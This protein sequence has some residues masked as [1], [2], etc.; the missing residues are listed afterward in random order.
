LFFDE[1]PRYV[2]LRHETPPQSARPL[3][4]DL[5]LE[6]GSTLRTWAL[7]REP[8][9]GEAVPAEALPD[10]RLDYLNYE[11]P[12]SN[13]R[14]F[15]RRWDEGEFR[16]LRESPE[17]IELEFHGARLQARAVL[18]FRQDLPTAN[19]WTLSLSLM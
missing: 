1:M 7:S 3:H 2:I 5:M 11:G 14:G 16:T 9:M 4:W 15:V 8:A 18:E 13:Q 12:V 19:Q 6:S 10:H 17:C